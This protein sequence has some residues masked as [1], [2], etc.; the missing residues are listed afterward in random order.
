MKA[1]GYEYVAYRGDRTDLVS[2]DVGGQELWFKAPVEDGLGGLGDSGTIITLPDGSQV[3]LATTDGAKY[4]LSEEGANYD[5]VYQYLK[6]EVG[7]TDGRIKDLLEGA[8]GYSRA[9]KNAS[10]KDIDT[11]ISQYKT[12]WAKEGD[13]GAGTRE[14]FARNLI[15]GNYEGSYDIGSLTEK[16]VLDYVY[17]NVSDDW[18][19]KNKKGKWWNPFD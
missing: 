10:Y 2:F 14:D 17:E 19:T 5:N 18:L 6:E 11:Y 1:D 16:E 9:D 13:K 12:S 4:L 3:D 15:A 7:L 8:G